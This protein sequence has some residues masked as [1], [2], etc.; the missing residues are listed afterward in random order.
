MWDSTATV[1]R[2]RYYDL[3]ERREMRRT[4]TEELV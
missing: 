1:H 3:S 4:T 2:G